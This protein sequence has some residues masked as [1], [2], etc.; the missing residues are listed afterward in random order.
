MNERLLDFLRKSEVNRL[1]EEK[2]K[3]YNFI[4]EAE[5]ALAEKAATVDE[6]FSLVLADS[7]INLA[8]N[9]FQLP[10]DQVVSLLADI[11]EELNVKI[12]RRSEKVKWIDFSE[13]H[14]PETG[15]E[16]KNRLFLFINE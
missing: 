6:F 15:S 14:N 9:H 10:Y 7:P 4:T 11:E 12:K 16:R 8:M 5:D 1:S 3:L 13:K 2:R